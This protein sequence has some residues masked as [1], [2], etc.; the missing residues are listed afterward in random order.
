[1]H[2]DAETAWITSRYAPPDDDAFQY[3]T[4]N[5]YMNVEYRSDSYVDASIQHAYVVSILRKTY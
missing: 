5:L 1:M 3:P 2:A 4:I